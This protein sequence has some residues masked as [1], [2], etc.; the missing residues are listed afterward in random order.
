MARRL[1]SSLLGAALVVFAAACA[2]EEPELLEA[3]V[4]Q[5]VAAATGDLPITE[6]ACA[7]VADLE[8]IVELDFVPIECTAL[9]SGDLITLDVALIRAD[10]ESIEATVAIETPILDVAAVETE[11]A[12][13]LDADIGGAPAV[14]CAEAR[15]VIAV[16]REINCRVTAEGGTAGPVDR[17]AV[18]RIVDADGTWE[19]DLTPS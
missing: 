7:G 8:P 14:R 16:G 2:D 18:V 1:T 5:A 6:L 17:P 9:L 12:E 11:A 13:R 19:L 4:E 10:A 3:D 15:V